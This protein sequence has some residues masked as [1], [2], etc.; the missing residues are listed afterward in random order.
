MGMVKRLSFILTLILLSSSCYAL[1]MTSADFGS[2]KA[3]ERAVKTILVGADIRDNTYVMSSEGDI[4]KWVSVSPPEIFVPAYLSGT[5]TLVLDVPANTPSGEYRGLI[6]ASGKTA[7]SAG[8]SSNSANYLLQIKSKAKVYVISDIPGNNTVVQPEETAASEDIASLSVIDLSLD[9]AAAEQGDN[10][11]INVKVINSGTKPVSGSVFV[12][13][14][15]Q[16]ESIK[17]ISDNIPTL[18]V[19]EEKTITLNLG[20][21]QMQA[22]TYDVF[23]SAQVSGSG[24]TP[25]K[26]GPAKLSLLAVGEEKAIGPDVFWA[27][28]IIFLIL[29][30]IILYTLLKR[31]YEESEKRSERGNIQKT[32][33]SLNSKLDKLIDEEKEL[34]K[35]LEI[36][37]TEIREI[38]DTLKKVSSKVDYSDSEYTQKLA[39]YIISARKRGYPSDYIESHLKDQGY[40]TKDINKAF[41]R[42]LDQFR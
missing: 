35:T 26:Y 42:V 23:A 38:K 9:P 5:I 21:S 14:V 7:I 2:V 11:Q 33:Y 3:G 28:L 8:E 29:F 19:A 30:A 17:Y 41:K 4:S 36:K 39:N 40:S 16:G 13:I 15:K 1:T 24:T 31:K 22:G 25:Q 10:I 27:A 12:E 32:I 18:G 6:V 37:E 20:T 34:R